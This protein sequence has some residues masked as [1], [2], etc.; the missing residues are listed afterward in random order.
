M[1][2]IEYG[3]S[4]KRFAMVFAATAALLPAS[5][6]GPGNGPNRFS[7]PALGFVPAATATALQPILGI[8]GAAR[9][10]DPISLPN[11]V[12]QTYIAPGHSYALAAQGPAGPMAL[13]LLRSAAGI[14]TNPVLAPMPGVMAYADLVAFNPSG[15][16]AALYSKQANRIQVF[17]GLPASPHLSE[18]TSNL[19][20]GGDAGLLALSDDAQCLLIADATGTVYALSPNTAPVPVFH[21]SQISALV[22]VSH[23]HDAIVCDPV[24]G[25]A[26]V[27]QV[28]TAS[29]GV[30]TLQPPSNSSCQPRAA[31][32]T[33]D[34]G[35]LLI[36]CPAQH[37][38]WSVDRA[39]GSTNAYS[40]SNG[41]TA[42]DSVG[43]RD[44]FLMSPP[45][46]GI[47]WILTWRAGGPV[48][49]FIG[50]AHPAMP[51]AGN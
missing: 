2:L 23:S 27:L 38:I 4:M 47:Y 42:L 40:V 9:L 17:T 45:D 18:D 19:Q 3:N 12:T 25:S 39:S 49:S 34:G 29:A 30:Q 5:G 48:A 15:G 24:L 41:P 6:S 21:S 31:A 20:I 7:G 11:T 44:V 22:F 33:A 46:N 37:L 14:Q 43:A 36:A 26:A 8:P 51:V 16:A 28:S 13:I 35:T 32:S 10:G 50:A 1:P